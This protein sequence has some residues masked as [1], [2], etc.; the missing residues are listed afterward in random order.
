[1]TL[2]GLHYETFLDTVTFKLCHK[3]YITI[4]LALYS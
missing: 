3:K 1:M 4:Y 2:I